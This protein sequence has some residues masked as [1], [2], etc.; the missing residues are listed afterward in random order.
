MCRRES[1]PPRRNRRIAPQMIAFHPLE[2]RRVISQLT[3]AEMRQ[4][5]Q[6][7]V[8]HG[9]RPRRRILDGYSSA[10]KTGTAQKVDPMPRMPI[11]A[12]STWLPLPVSRPVNNPAI[13]VASDPRFG[14][15]LAPGRSDFR[16]GLSTHRAAGAGVSARPARCR[17]AGQ[18]PVAVGGEPGEGAGFGGGFAG[19]SWGAIGGCG[20]HRNRR[21]R[22][23]PPA[24]ARL[25]APEDG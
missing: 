15:G 9:H 10:G 22:N 24:A 20:G 14:S 13:T 1:L 11:R 17:I 23:I 25:H 19:S 18:P 6:G 8:L 12:P 5:M 7:V 21:T 3:A 4:M 16:S 2:Q